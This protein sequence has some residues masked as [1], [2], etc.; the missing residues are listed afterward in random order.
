MAIADSLTFEQIIDQKTSGKLSLMNLD[1]P[2]KNLPKLNLEAEES[3]RWCYGQK[4]IFEP[5]YPDDFYLTY[6][7]HGDFIGISEKYQNEDI[8]LIK[9]KVMLYEQG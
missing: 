7:H 9:A 2:L 1:A 4:I 6:N 5:E 8:N 3:L